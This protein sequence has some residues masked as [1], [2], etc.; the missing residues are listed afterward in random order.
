MQADAKLTVLN[1]FINSGSGWNVSLRE[2][3]NRFEDLTRK[4][5]HSIL[6]RHGS[7]ELFGGCRFAIVPR[8]RIA[9][10]YFGKVRVQFR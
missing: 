2:Y 10:R 4:A 9:F 5:Y 8:V 3:T 1:A 6:F 7:N